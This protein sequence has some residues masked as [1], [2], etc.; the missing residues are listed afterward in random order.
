MFEKI[1]NIGM[2]IL[3]VFYVLDAIIILLGYLTPTAFSNG[4]IRL[5]LALVLLFGTYY[6][7]KRSTL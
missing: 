6:K 5:A 1:I 2:K 3:G 4:I 7:S